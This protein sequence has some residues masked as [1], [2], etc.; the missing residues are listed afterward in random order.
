[1]SSSKPSSVKTPSNRAHR[2]GNTVR[3]SSS[4][5]D[6]ALNSIWH[7]SAALKSFAFVLNIKC[8]EA[9]IL[10]N[11]LA[12]TCGFLLVFSTLICAL[13][14]PSAETQAIILKLQAA[15][16]KDLAEA[17]DPQVGASRQGDCAAQADLA[18]DVIKKLQHGFDVPKWQIELASEVP[19]K[20]V[21]AEKDKLCVANC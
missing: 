7:E 3:S 1:M 11:L 15:K 2:R 12:A 14:E 5:N 6:S 10:R 21:K 20:S 17:N 18:D 9:F 19:P 13:A 16:Q 8:N 4:S